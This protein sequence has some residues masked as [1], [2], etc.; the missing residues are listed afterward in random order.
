MGIVPGTMV[1]PKFFFVG[2]YICIRIKK[3][4]DLTIPVSSIWPV[5]QERINGVENELTR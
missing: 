3:D 5:L 1:C 2:L 4:I